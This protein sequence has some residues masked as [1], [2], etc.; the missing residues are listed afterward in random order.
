M[1]IPQISHWKY[2]TLPA[3]CLTKHG[4][5][6]CRSGSLAS[7]LEGSKTQIYP[8]QIDLF[9]R[10]DFVRLEQLDKTVDAIRHRY[11][12]DSLVRAVFINQKN[13]EGFREIDH[14]EGGVSR[15]KRSVDYS[16]IRII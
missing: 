7:I 14:M 12:N 11:G 8:R 15:E 5:R 2:T 6:E 3:A 10:M 1:R 16:K 9:D 4:R 13:V